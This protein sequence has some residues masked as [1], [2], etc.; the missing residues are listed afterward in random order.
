[1]KFDRDLKTVRIHK[2]NV[3]KTEFLSSNN[4][5]LWFV[6]ILNSNETYM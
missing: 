4:L 1:M 3:Y 5:F 6:S 2:E